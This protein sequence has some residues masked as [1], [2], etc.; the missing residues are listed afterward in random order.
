MSNRLKV[1]VER[2]KWLRGEG[3]EKSKLLRSKDGKMCC[4]GFACLA[5]GATT[6]Q[7]SDMNSPT[8][9]CNMGG[10]LE[11]PM[12]TMVGA[13]H[14][15]RRLVN[16]APVDEAMMVN[17]ERFTSESAREAKLT[18]LLAQVD[19]DLEFVD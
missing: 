16:K 4:L 10:V 1:V 2:S 12:L 6:V 17:D 7:I 8:M 15:S 19:I 5:M 9:A 14:P 11:L 18:E 3:W 13:D